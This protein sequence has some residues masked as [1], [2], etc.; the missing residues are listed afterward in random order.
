VSTTIRELLV[1]FG[2]DADTAELSEFDSAISSA[3]SNMA[4]AA[5]AAAVLAAGVALVAG[6]VAGVINSARSAG[7][8]IDKNSQAL[9]MN[10]REY[11]SVVFAAQQGGAELEQLR[12][13][14]TQL[15]AKVQAA[16]KAGDD[17]VT[18]LDGT[19]MAIRGANG[20]TLTQY[21]LLGQI[22]DAVRA[23]TT[24]EDKL[25]IATSLL[26]MEGG[27]RLIPMLENGAAGLD[28]MADRAQNLGFIMSDELVKASANLTDRMGEVRGVVS[29]LRNTIAEKLIP[30]VNEMLE[31]FLDWYEANADLIKQKVEVWAMKVEAAI[32]AI[33]DAISTIEEK[34]D[35]IDTLVFALEAAAVAVG[36]LSVGLAA[37]AGAKAWAGISAGY[38]ALIT[39][40]ELV[41]AAVGLAFW[42]VVL[43][44]AAVAA[45][46]AAIVF[47]VDDLI[48]FFSGADSALGT[49]IERNKDANTLLGVLARNLQLVVDIG[50][51]FVDLFQAIWSLVGLVAGQFADKFDPQ[52]KQAIELMRAFGDVAMQVADIFMGILI[53][54]T[55]LFTSGPMRL[56]LGGLQ[57]ATAGVQGITDSAGLAPSASMAGGGGSSSISNEVNVSMNGGDANAQDVAAV[58]EQALARSNRDALASMAGAEA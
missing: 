47:I 7:D 18:L 46:I 38:T 2:V 14:M 41:A 1:A 33:S 21:Q 8:E 52:I 19:T 35:I 42:E 43:I 4:S 48:A 28:S 5:K 9:A 10:A 27:A 29:G 22:A 40:V 23:A 39:G 51:A 56:L 17:Y 6:A 12:G 53:P 15:N 34:I 31:R 54:A 44:A 37:F 50:G 16:T 26:G 57:S 55:D 30:V 3:S 20:E 32:V 25:T 36:V 58:I 45:A 24:E 11:Q 13:G 49:F